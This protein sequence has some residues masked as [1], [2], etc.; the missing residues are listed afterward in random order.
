MDSPRTGVTERFPRVGSALRRN[1]WL[2]AAGAALLAFQSSVLLPLPGTPVLSPDNLLF[3]YVGYNW[4]EGYPPYRTVWDLKPPAL[5]EA[6]ALLAA[7][8]GG[9]PIVHH[10]LNV[11]ITNLLLT[12]S[13]VLVAKLTHSIT[14]RP[15]PALVAGL[16]LLASPAAL[17]YAMV[18]T[19]AE[20]Y[21]IFLGLLSLYWIRTE[22]YVLAGAA[23]TLAAGFYQMA[24]VFPAV[25]LAVTATRRRRSL[26]PVVGAMVATTVAVVLPVVLS[27][28]GVPMLNQVVGGASVGT[29][30]ADPA[31]NAGKLLS[32]LRR[33]VIF[34]LDVSGPFTAVFL[35]GGLF[36]ASSAL[37]GDR[38]TWPYVVPAV[39][40]LVKVLA[41]D[42]D[43]FLDLLPLLAFAGLGIGLSF[44]TRS[45]WDAPVLV[46]LAV[47]VCA[48]LVASLH[49][50]AQLP[51]AASGDPAGLLGLYF[52]ATPPPRC[53]IRL[54]G[55]ELQFIE[56]TGGSRT[57][58][59]CR[60][61]FLLDD[62]W[63][64]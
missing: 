54:S 23:G 52:D 3:Q 5:F 61:E 2:V 19:F 46:G 44:R 45:R 59:V 50:F 22:R 28:A 64:G 40:F 41:F 7:V 10:W 55:A 39:W 33:F 25:V 60:T 34:D 42:Y 51:P 15:W 14:G 49:V 56:R 30:A 20:Y 47:L 9:D 31:K 26:K 38:E 63:F 29:G 27:G 43:S 37:V 36:G 12:G 57:A 58:G 53:H 62:L 16:S 21:V 13:V 17:T 8:S 6:T 4:V 35:V 18:G 24:V 32:E 1:W 48:S 11:A